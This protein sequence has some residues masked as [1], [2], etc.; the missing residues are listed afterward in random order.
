MLQRSLTTVGRFA[1]AVLA[2]AALVVAG[3]AVLVAVARQRF[4]SA[5]PLHQIP[6]PWQWSFAQIV[7][8]LQSQLTNDVVINLLI[9]GSSPVR[10]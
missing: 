7:E 10:I 5:N 8:A 4:E 1:G 6:W 9:R 2:L 3:P